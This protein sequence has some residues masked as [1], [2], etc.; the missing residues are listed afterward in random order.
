MLQ[1]Q[2][3]CVVKYNIFDDDQKK[4]TIFCRFFFI[5]SLDFI[6]TKKNITGEYKLWDSITKA[7]FV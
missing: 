7:S 3:N 5:L 2:M 4:E 6:M 1:R